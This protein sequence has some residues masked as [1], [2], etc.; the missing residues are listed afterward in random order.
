MNLY[1]YRYPN[2]VWYRQ[3]FIISLPIFAFFI[4]FCLCYRS[5]FTFY[6]SSIIDIHLRNKE[7]AI[8]KRSKD[9]DKG[10]IALKSA[11]K[12]RSKDAR[13]PIERLQKEKE[14]R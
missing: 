11:I 13:I 3:F 12:K 4:Y 6:C 10:V 9:R 1:L 14:L 2:N 8:E 7:N 5:L